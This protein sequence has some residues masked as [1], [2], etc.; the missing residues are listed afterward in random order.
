ML[1]V[2]FM[3]LIITQCS[4]QKRI[5]IEQIDELVKSGYELGLFNG[6]VLVAYQ[7]EL[8]YKS[9]YGFQDLESKVPLQ[10]TSAFYLASVSKQFTTM[11]IMMLK[12]RGKLSFDDTLD[13]F[14]PQF[15]DYAKKVTIRHMMTHT[16]GIPDHFSLISDA[17]GLTN[18]RVLELLLKLDSL[19]FQPGEKY[20]YSNGA[21][22]LLSLIV[23][24]VSG[25]P[26]HI[27]MQKNIFNPLNM[28]NTLVYDES[29]PEVAQRAI[30]YNIF[31]DVND[32]TLFTTGAGG[33][34][35][36]VEDL[37]KWDQALYNNQLVK[38]ELLEEAYTPYILN[39]DS[40][41]HY[42]YGW[43]ILVDEHGKR[44]Q[45]S[46][47]LAGFSTYIERHLDQKNLIVFLCSKGT[48][49]GWLSRGIRN[50][51]YGEPYELPKAPIMIT[52]NQIYKNKGISETLLQYKRLKKEDRDTYIFDESQLN[53][54]GYYLLQNDKIEDAIEIFKLNTSEYPDSPNVYDSLG[55]GYDADNQLELAFRNYETAYKLGMRNSDRNVNIY[56]ANMDR[57]KKKLEGK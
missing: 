32:Y 39:N 33:M 42:G 6:T 44:V 13:K 37:Y 54:Y 2:V 16:S 55:D 5:K 17:T 9:A 52:L 4:N 50:I 49:L 7:G 34:Y 21:F 38:S 57:V 36:T 41:T 56:K 24:Q 22:V 18:Q 3:S 35:T 23:S 45:H 46:G 30:G 14:F 15:P 29:G 53:R 20:S 12:E 25:Q 47:G 27:F 51:L 48:L 26:F 43:G 11:A 40:S 1:L 8:L 19:L 28:K 31:G 10:T